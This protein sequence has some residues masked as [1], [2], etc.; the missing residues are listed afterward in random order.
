[1]QIK[2]S[3]RIFVAGKTGSGKTTLVK[4]MLFPMYTRRVFWDIKLENSDLAFC[5][6][7]CTTPDE[8][9]SSIKKGKTSILY[10][11]KSLEPFDFNRVCQILYE[12]GNFTLFVDEVSRVCTP[13]WI[14]PWHDEIM[15]RGRGRGVGIVNLTQ[16]PRRCHNTVISEA[17]HFFIFRLQLETDIAKI[18]E[19]L[20]RQW[21]NQVSSLPY[22]HCIY[23]DS[24]GTIKPLA[25]IRL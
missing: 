25:P 5:C 6:T 4:K 21:A 11:P 17:E 14:E 3:D 22:H 10:Q 2:S 19:I 9:R 23:S 18:K 16:R 13:S 12:T 1:M 20:P 7:I 24:V 8:L 15:T